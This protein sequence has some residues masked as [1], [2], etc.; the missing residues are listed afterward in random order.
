MFNP[1]CLLSPELLDAFVKA[2]HLYFVRQA[3]PRAKNLIDTHIKG[4]FLIT[5]HKTLN[6]ATEHF[7]AIKKD[8]NRYLY[9]WNKP[10]DREKIKAAA[11]QPEGYKIYASVVMPDVQQKA[12]LVL[13][14]KIKHYIDNKLK[15]RP[16]RDATVDFNLYPHYGEVHVTLKLRNQQVKVALSEIE[17]FK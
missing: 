15:W 10:T 6:N 3:Y 13:K 8:G 9:D 5:H 4:Y 12:E 14:K 17:L 1:L 16:G 2:G 11:A 7:E